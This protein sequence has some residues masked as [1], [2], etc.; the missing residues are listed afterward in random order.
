M[1]QDLG[2]I[3]NLR[4]ISGSIKIEVSQTRGGARLEELRI[5][6]DSGEEERPAVRI[7]SV[8]L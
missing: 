1:E 4:L 3:E 6:L 8:Q 7:A 5:D 2:N